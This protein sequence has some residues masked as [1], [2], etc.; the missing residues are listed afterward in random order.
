[1][2]KTFL[3]AIAAL[4]TALSASAFTYDPDVHIPVPSTEPASAAEYLHVNWDEVT[5]TP[6]GTSATYDVR[7]G[8]TVDAGH[9]FSAPVYA[10]IS[11]SAT[12]EVIALADDAVDVSLPTNTNLRSTGYYLWSF[13]GK[14]SYGSAGGGNTLWCSLCY[15]D[16]EGTV[17][18]ISTVEIQKSG[19]TGV[20]AAI[21]DN[22]DDG[23]A[24][25]YTLS[26]IRVAAPT[27]GSICIVRQGGKAAKVIR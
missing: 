23:A 10:V 8:L 9:T 20:E 1:M 2:K 14:T 26:G 13:N 24:E 5:V 7:A 21:H 22:S 3:P 6:D 15:T 12:G 4:A 19:T 27:A 17:I 11:T 16:S 25:Y 18:P